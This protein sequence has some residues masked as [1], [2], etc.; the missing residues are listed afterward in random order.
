[1]L[2]VLCLLTA[3]RYERMQR[4]IVTKESYNF[5]NFIN[6]ARRSGDL[7]SMLDSNKDV[8]KL[9]AMKILIGVKI[10]FRGLF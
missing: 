7:R 2:L 4:S 1:M 10:H 9:E 5:Q 6:F 8:L 3:T